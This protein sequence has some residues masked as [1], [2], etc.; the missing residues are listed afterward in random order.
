[1][2]RL[3]KMMALGGLAALGAATAAEAQY[4]PGPPGYG[5]PP[6]YGQPP[7]YYGQPRRQPPGYYG[8]GYYQPR[9]Q[10]QFGQVCL[11]SRG[12]CYTGR[13]LQFGTGCGC[14]IPGFGFKRGAIG[15]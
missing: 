15:G 12:S 10:V 9:P 7:G 5:P 2:K 8:G 13:P 11:T 3:L 1:M 6:G 14:S 4:Y